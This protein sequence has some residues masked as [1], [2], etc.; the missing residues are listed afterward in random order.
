M[1][2]QQVGAGL[3]AGA[4]T[5][6]LWWHRRTVKDAQ[7][8]ASVAQ[9]G[10]ARVAAD[11]ESAV[12]RLLVE[13]MNALEKEVERLTHAEN[14]SRLRERALEEHIFH[15]ENLMRKAGMDVPE[16]VRKLG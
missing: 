9:A 3:A 13:R 5:V 11:A 16:R 7:D 1:D 8:K 2:W 4:S 15:L 14:E 10:L 12:Y 6:L